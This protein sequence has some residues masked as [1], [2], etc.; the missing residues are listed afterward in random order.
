MKYLDR[1]EIGSKHWLLGENDLMRLSTLELSSLKTCLDVGASPVLEHFQ[2]LRYLDVSGSAVDVNSLMPAISKIT[3]LETLVML[4]LAKISFC[5]SLQP[6][7]TLVRLTQLS[8]DLCEVS[9]S[10]LKFLPSLQCLSVESFNRDDEILRELASLPKLR[11]LKVG[12]MYRVNFEL[13]TRLS[14]LCRSRW[15]YY[16]V[17]DKEW[18]TNPHDFDQDYPIH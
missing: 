10:T 7:S 6:L 4:D 1:L 17:K 11:Y 9:S 16:S 14:G 18:R 13:L 8:T 5:G 3:S 2:H 12:F 15:Q